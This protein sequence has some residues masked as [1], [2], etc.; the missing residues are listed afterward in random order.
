[1]KLFPRW[2]DAVILGLF[3]GLCFSFWGQPPGIGAALCGILYSIHVRLPNR[4]I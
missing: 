4:I 3:L 2:Y 1:M